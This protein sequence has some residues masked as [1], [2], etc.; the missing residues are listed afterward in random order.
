MDKISYDYKL[1]IQT[2]LDIGFGYL[3]T[4][5]NFPE[6]DWKLSFVK[7]IYLYVF[8]SAG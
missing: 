5:T 1:R 4:V 2:F 7:A 8:S 3:I 6:K